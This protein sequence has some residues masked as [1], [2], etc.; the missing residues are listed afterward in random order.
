MPSFDVIVIGTGQAGPFLASRL[1]SA[2]MKVAVVERGAFGGTCVNTGCMPTKT[3]VAS[4][5]AAHVARR[6]A[7]YGVSVGGAIAVDMARVKARKNRISGESRES[8]EAT[9]RGLPNGRVYDGHARFESAN[10]L[11]AREVWFR[12]QCGRLTVQNARTIATASSRRAIG[13][14]FPAARARRARSA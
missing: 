1:A 2:G 13:R 11:S 8:T 10:N 7:E 4:A 3:L 5:F 6:G 12:R 14:S 9:M